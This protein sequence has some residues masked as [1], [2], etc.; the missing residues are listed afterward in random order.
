MDECLQNLRKNNSKISTTILEKIFKEKYLFQTDE[1]IKYNT[2][3]SMVA[4][5]GLSK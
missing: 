4:V 5:Y 2:S 1:Q 3:Y